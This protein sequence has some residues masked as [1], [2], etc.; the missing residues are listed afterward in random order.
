M[1]SN[2]ENW[3]VSVLKSA[4]V[5]VKFSGAGEQQG[6]IRS[7]KTPFPSDEREQAINMSVFKVWLDD[8]QEI[9]CQGQYFSRVNAQEHP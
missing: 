8:G 1:L 9:E 2:M 7:V 4:K 3:D 6:T 5:W